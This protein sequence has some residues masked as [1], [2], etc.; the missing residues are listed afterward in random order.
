MLPGWVH[1][2]VLFLIFGKSAWYGNDDLKY[3]PA[4]R[5]RSFDDN[6]PLIKNFGRVMIQ[7]SALPLPLKEFAEIRW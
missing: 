5:R 7:K 4:F 2:G 1:D 3:K 6:D